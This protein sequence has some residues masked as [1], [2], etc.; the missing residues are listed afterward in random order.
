MNSNTANSI[1][2]TNKILIGKVMHKRLLPRQ[3]FFIYNVFYLILNVLNIKNSAKQSKW[4]SYNKFNL[5]SFYEKDHSTRTKNSNGYNWILDIINNS[6]L[7]DKINLTSIEILTLPAMLGYV[8]NPVSFWLLYNHN[9]ELISVLYEVNNTFG[10]TH[11]YLCYKDD[12]SKIEPSDTLVA[13]KK[14]YVSPFF[15]VEG[16]YKFKIGLLEDKITL[17]IDYYVDN[18]EVL[19]TSLTGKLIAFDNK[20]LLKCFIKHPLLTLRAIILIHYHAIRLIIKKIPFFGTQELDKQ[21]NFNI[22]TN[23]KEKH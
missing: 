5:L 20:N 22:S 1:L 4:F 10:Y 6:N 12:F 8:F 11:S 23:N 13:Q 15:K 3:H 17:F 16:E 2:T 7:K 9:K 18:K 21:N 19:K 14:F